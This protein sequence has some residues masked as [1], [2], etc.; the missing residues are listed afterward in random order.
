M[1]SALPVVH[2]ITPYADLFG[3][4]PREFV[5]DRFYNMVP[6]IGFAD[7]ATAWKRWREVSDEEDSDS[8][9]EDTIWANEWDL[10]YSM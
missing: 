8:D 1:D 5:F 4:H 10:E 6:A 3:M 9:G 7:V 2:E